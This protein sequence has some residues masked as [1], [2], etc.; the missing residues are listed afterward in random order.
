MGADAGK[1]LSN[2]SFGPGN[3]FLANKA[4]DALTPKMP[5]A[6]NM[7]APP[8]LQDAQVSDAEAQQRKARGRAATIFGGGGQSLSGGGSVSSRVLLGS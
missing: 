6:P 2:V 4:M 8:S 1:I 7:P 3:V 5:D